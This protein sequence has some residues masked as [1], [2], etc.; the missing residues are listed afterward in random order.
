MLLE[1]H[2]KSST[3]KQRSFQGVDVD[4]D[5]GSMRSESRWVM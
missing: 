3:V 2:K 1:G 5:E 4:E